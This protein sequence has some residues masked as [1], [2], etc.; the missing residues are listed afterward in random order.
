M[1]KSMIRKTFG[2]A[3]KCASVISARAQRRGGLFDPRRS[4]RNRMIVPG[5][6]VFRSGANSRTLDCLIGDMSRGGAR[7][8]VKP[9][10]ATPD[11]VILIH[12]REWTA[13]EAKVVWRRADGNLGI[14]FKRSHD[15]KGAN[16]PELRSLRDYC[17]ASADAK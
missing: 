10:A 6:L 1:W 4:G 2:K 13:Y 9:M 17:V 14:A 15:L 16:S 8:R 12:L 11:A 3:Q 5:M 7:L